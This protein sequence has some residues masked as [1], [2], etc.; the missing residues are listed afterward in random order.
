L[1]TD[2]EPPSMLRS[3]SRSKSTS[4]LPVVPGGRKYHSTGVACVLV[5]FSMFGYRSPPPR[6]SW[7]PRRFAISVIDGD[8]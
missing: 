5:R 1:E 3:V 8:R 4:W 6:N 7:E 2:E